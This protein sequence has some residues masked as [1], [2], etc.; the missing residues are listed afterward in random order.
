MHTAHP[1]LSRILRRAAPRLTAVLGILAVCL[2]AT[3]KSC[4]LIM[5]NIENRDGLQFAV[6][7]SLQDINGEATDTF[8]LGEPVQLVLTV[9]NE[10]ETSAVVEFSTGRT[11]DF[12]VLERGDS[13][14]VWKW[15]DRRS[16]AQAVTQIEFASGETKTFTQVWN[17]VDRNGAPVRSGDYEARGVLVFSGFDADPRIEHEMGSALQTIR[18]EADSG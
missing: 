8:E 14:V 15:S 3:S 17:Q 5:D 6:A 10:L 2:G 1:H 16:F 12:V 11:F 13:R 7:L 9:R 4:R 18:I